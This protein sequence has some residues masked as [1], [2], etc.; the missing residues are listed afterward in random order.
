[1]RPRLQQ[2]PT[3]DKDV[4]GTYSHGR[5]VSLREQPRARTTSSNTT[6]AEAENGL[7]IA[8][9]P[10]RIETASGLPPTKAAGVA[11]TDLVN[12]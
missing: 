2:R 3:S 6:Q 5:A 10:G 9:S 12:W 8:T 1:M 7:E 4:L 11:H